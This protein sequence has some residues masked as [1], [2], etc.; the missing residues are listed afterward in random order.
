M[1]EH[2]IQSKPTD[3]ELYNNPTWIDEMSPDAWDY[4]VNK[5]CPD[6]RIL[7]VR[8]K[9]AI[10]VMA[11]IN[12][13]AIFKVKEDVY[14][15]L[16][17]EYCPAIE[18]APMW[19]GETRLD[20]IVGDKDYGEAKKFGL[21]WLEKGKTYILHKE[22]ATLYEVEDEAELNRIKELADQINIASAEL[23]IYLN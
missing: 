18:A 17:P 11:E 14:A 5:Y 3:E 12:G 1:K 2:T 7:R 6:I 10:E 4:L 8:P 20:K 9:D 23:D 22:N 13:A 16:S 19:P 21:H 15:Q